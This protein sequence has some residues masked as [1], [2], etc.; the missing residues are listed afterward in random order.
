MF[1]T[2][3]ARPARAGVDPVGKHQLWAFV[4]RAAARGA[5][6]VM[7]THSMEDVEATCTRIGIMVDGRL[8]CLGTAQELRN[9]HG[10]GFTVEMRLPPP[11]EPAVAA[12]LRALAD[13][14]ATVPAP[15]GAPLGEATL[16]RAACRAAADALGNGARADEIAP[17]ASG[18]AVAAAAAAS[19]RRGGAFPAL[20]F[21]S[22]WAECD[23]A[24]AAIAYVT[25]DAFPG[26]ALAERQ[27][28][29]LKFRVPPM[30]EVARAAAAAGGAGTATPPRLRLSNM[31]ARLEAARQ[32]FGGTL[33]FSQCTLESV[34]NFYAAQQ[35]AEEG[36]PGGSAARRGLLLA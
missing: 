17:S 9:A 27:G 22:W 8:R 12:V 26:A 21:A 32:I 11:G 30:D 10:A 16:T 5:A 4:A 23:A 36:A 3:R 18:W 2:D 13:A 31:F 29:A 25:R 20:V 28:L 34:F 15:P 33:A 35:R 7:T 6:V 14:G 19:P 1:T 24:D